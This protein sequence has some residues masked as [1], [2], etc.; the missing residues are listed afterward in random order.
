M[1]TIYPVFEHSII[2]K[3]L[4]VDND[5]VIIALSGGKD[6]V[7]LSLLLKEFQNK[8]NFKLIAAYYN[9][10]IRTDYNEEELWVKNFCNNNNIELETDTG[11]VKQ[12]VK[13]NSLNLENGASIMR[14]NFFNSLLTRYKN[15]KIFTAHSKSDSTETFL[16]KLFRGSGLQGL[17]SISLIK[18]K[19]FYRPLLHFT[20]EDIINFLNRNK[21]KFY[22]DYSNMD[23]N[24]LRNKIRNE[25]IPKIKKIEPNIDNSINKTIEIIKEEYNYFEN[26]TRDILQKNLIIKTILP[27]SILSE[28]HL[29]VKRHIIREYIRLIKGNLFNIGFEHINDLLNAIANKH[30]I[31][32]PGVELTIS[33]GYLYPSDTV[34]NSYKYYIN[35]Q[36]VEKT[37]KINEIEQKIIIKKTNIFKKPLNNHQIIIPHK[38]L[39]F[40][41]IIHSPK[42][43]DKYIKINSNINMSVYEMI[44]SLNIP[45]KLRNLYPVITDANEKIIWSLGSPIADEFKVQEEKK[46]EQY[47]QIINPH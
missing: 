40:P 36:D 41:L 26:L 23:N 29:A 32:I 11:N 17:S 34:I 10:R 39:S 28:H 12:Y 38:L 3:N 37:I 44:R 20:K 4:I 9:H 25:L 35:Q 6:S 13:E 15:S 7:T 31:A 18:N 47:I 8:I 46:N 45:T 42:K 22:T 2:E 19:Q 43:T 14:Y 5:T 1:K 33:K 16:I 27:V 21:I 24:F 30:S